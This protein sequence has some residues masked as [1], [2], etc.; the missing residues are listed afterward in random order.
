MSQKTE[1]CTCLDGYTLNSSEVYGEVVNTFTGL[2]DN[3]IVTEWRRYNLFN[4]Y[5]V[6]FATT[7]GPHNL[8]PFNSNPNVNSI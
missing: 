5:F 7:W 1:L 3:D 8:P 4:R 6:N 2:S